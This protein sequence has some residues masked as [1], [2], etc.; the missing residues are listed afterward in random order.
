MLIYS[1]SYNGKIGLE[2][3]RFVEIFPDSDFR[4]NNYFLSF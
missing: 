4:T 2:G 1:S 3:I